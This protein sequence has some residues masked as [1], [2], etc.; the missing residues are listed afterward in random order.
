MGRFH[1]RNEGVLIRLQSL[2]HDRM[3][4]LRDLLAR[5]VTNKP[6]DYPALRG[7]RVTFSDV[8]NHLWEKVNNGE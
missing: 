8:I 6:E 5:A 3:L 2:A 7:K 4:L 1:K